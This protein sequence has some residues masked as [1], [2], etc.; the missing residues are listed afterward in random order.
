MDAITRAQAAHFRRTF[1]EHGPNSKGVDWGSPEDTALLYDQML[2]VI[3]P[4]D[5]NKGITLLD[6]GCGYGG[7][8]LHALERG[9]LQNITYT[10]IDVVHEM[11]QQAALRFPDAVFIEQDVLT[12]DNP[13]GFDYVVCNGVLTTHFSPSLR[14]TDRWMKRVVMKLFELCRRGIAF[15]TMTTQVNYT[16]P[17][18][19]YKSPVELLAWC[20]SDISSYVRL[21]HAYSAFRPKKQFHYTVYAYR[22]IDNDAS[23]DR[24]MVSGEE[25]G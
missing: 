16:E 25:N 5:A 19:F 4:L 6:V 7:L 15:N 24:C 10:G 23:V 13:R 3:E 11:L 9:L 2:N 14:D 22:P 20:L 8:Y 17:H 1:A 12:Y 21:D 18:L